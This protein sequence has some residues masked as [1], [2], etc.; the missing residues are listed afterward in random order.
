MLKWLDIHDPQIVRKALEDNTKNVFQKHTTDDCSI[1]L[2]KRSE[3]SKKKGTPISMKDFYHNRE[4]HDCVLGY[5]G[6]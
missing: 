3:P 5:L 4:K 6:F 1:I 2:L